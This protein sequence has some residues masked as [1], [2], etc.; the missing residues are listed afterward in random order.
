MLAAGL[1]LRGQILRTRGFYDEA[2]KVSRAAVESAR[3]TCGDRHPDT[4]KA[5]HNRGL[6]LVELGRFDE[7][8]VAVR[9]ALS[10]YRGADGEHSRDLDEGVRALGVIAEQAGDLD[11]ARRRYQQLVDL[12]AGLDPP[13]P[14]FEGCAVSVL[15]ILEVR[16]GNPELG[17]KH[18]ERAERLMESAAGRSVDCRVANRVRFGRA[19]MALGRFDEAEE[20][21]EAALEAYAGPPSI[22]VSRRTWTKA[23][24]GAE[25]A[26][27]ELNELRTR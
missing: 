12:R 11:A 24:R 22:G 10:I 9:E 2:A 13:N 3:V 27:A 17:L 4:A 21:I 6:I 5:L 8:E 16:A 1:N 25:E 15:G 23:Q 18:I 20:A 26:L 14:A 7:A 19:Y